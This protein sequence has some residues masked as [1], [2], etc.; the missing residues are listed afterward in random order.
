M[1]TTGMVISLNSSSLAPT[2]KNSELLL[3]IITA[4]A[5]PCCALNACVLVQRVNQ[6]TLIKNVQS[7]LLIATTAPV[8]FELTSSEHP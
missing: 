4:E 2:V 7:P 6:H 8:M 1:P 5:F 3:T